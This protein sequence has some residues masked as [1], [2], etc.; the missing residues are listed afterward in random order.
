MLAVLISMY[1][2]QAGNRKMFGQAKK[3]IVTKS[4]WDSV[5]MLSCHLVGPIVL[6]NKQN[7]TAKMRE[8]LASD[9]MWVRRSSV[10]HQLAFSGEILPFVE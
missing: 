6:R 1:T 3:L 2:H 10:L 9:N 5:D 7:G 4:W 8:W